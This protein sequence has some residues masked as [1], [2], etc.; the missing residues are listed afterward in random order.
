M[1]TIKQVVFWGVVGLS[2]AS[3]ATGLLGLVT[4]R[5]KSCCTIGL[6]S[7]FTLLL[8]LAMLVIGGIL[9]AVTVASNMQVD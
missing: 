3:I 9:M 5:A 4:A 6:Y 2:G 8:T 7:F 1:H